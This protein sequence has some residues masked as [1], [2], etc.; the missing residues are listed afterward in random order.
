MSILSS[1]LGL[2]ADAASAAE[3]QTS[4]TDGVNAVWSG[5]NT[6]VTSNI[7]LILVVVVFG[8]LFK[9]YVSPWL[10]GK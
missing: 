8:V 2:S 6:F 3:L 4:A 10:F 5:I 9:K 1:F 7:A